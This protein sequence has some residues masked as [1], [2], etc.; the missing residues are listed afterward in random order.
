MLRSE[1]RISSASHRLTLFIEA[2]FDHLEKLWRENNMIDDNRSGCDKPMYHLLQRSHLLQ[3][4]DAEVKQLAFQIAQEVIEAGNNI[5][6]FVYQV[7]FGR[8][9]LVNFVN[10]TVIGIEDIKDFVHIINSYFDQ[11]CYHAVTEFSNL[12]DKEIKEKVLY[13]D[14]SHKDRLSL[15]G[16]MSSS[17]V[18]EFRNPLTAVIGFVKLLKS[19]NPSLKYMDTIQ[20]ELDQ[21]KFRITQFLH[22]SKLEVID[23]QQEKIHIIPLFDDIL[24]F[25]YPTFV[26]DDVKVHTD[27]EPNIV[28]DGYRDEIKQVI[29]NLILNSIDALKLNHK[30]RE[31]TIKCL[32]KEG[33]I[34]LQVINNG[35]P[36]P[37]NVQRTMFEPFYTTKELG[38]GIGLYVCRKIIMKHKGKIS[39]ESN[40]AHT[41]FSILLP[42]HKKA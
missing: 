41:T 24:S 39:C 35:P 11:F 6:E 40:E 36:I 15:L 7:N 34:L 3:L 10:E 2:N 32:R 21:L 38:T 14:Q 16:Q 1:K 31:I 37:A 20:H 13:M 33:T 17:F 42:C 9:T 12:K 29:L 23:K 22:T 18:H 27:F 28:I 8:S 30:Q 19:E 25:L 26:D 5:G 4:S